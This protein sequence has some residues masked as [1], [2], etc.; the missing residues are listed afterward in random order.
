MRDCRRGVRLNIQIVVYYEIMGV[1]VVFVIMQ[2]TWKLSPLIRI[3]AARR[4][5]N[6][7]LEPTRVSSASRLK[8]TEL[9]LIL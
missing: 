5:I 4:P 1:D 3:S 6:A 2:A 7:E 9:C 8:R